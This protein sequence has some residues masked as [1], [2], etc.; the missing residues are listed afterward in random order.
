MK[1]KYPT[2]LQVKEI[3]SKHFDKKISQYQLSKD[4]GFSRQTISKY[5]RLHGVSPLKDKVNG[6]G[7]NKIQTDDKEIARLYSQ[8]YMSIKSIADKM[9]VNFTVINSRIKSSGIELREKKLQAKYTEIPHYQSLKAKWKSE[10][11]KRDSFLCLW[12]QNEKIDTKEPLESHHIIPRRNIKE[13]KLLFSIDN[14][15]TLCKYHHKKVNW[16]EKEHEI[17][18]HNLIRTKSSGKIA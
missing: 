8:E 7:W 14:G 1:Y 5:C 12:C 15:I 2:P 3:I 16:K 17:F 11:M 18:F 6:A 13:T 4:Y 10:V 9:N